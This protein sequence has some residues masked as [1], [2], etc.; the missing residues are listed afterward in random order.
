[1]MAYI[2]ISKVKELITEILEPIMAKSKTES[3][4][5]KF[6]TDKSETLEKNFQSA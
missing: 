1:M 4:F 5:V 2:S 3:V 6:L